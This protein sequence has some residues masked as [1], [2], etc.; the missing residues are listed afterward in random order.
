[1]KSEELRCDKSHFA[2]NGIY[3]VPPIKFVRSTHQLFSPLHWIV[4]PFHHGGVILLFLR[5]RG[6][7][8]LIFFQHFRLVLWNI[9]PYTE[10]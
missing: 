5:E 1:M 3:D 2:G 9:A 8:I 6:D 10:L 4:L 7:I